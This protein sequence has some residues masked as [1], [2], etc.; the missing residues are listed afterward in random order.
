MKNK[1]LEIVTC[2]LAGGHGPE[3]PLPARCGPGLNTNNLLCILIGHKK[4]QTPRLKLVRRVC[5]G[6][7]I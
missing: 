3:C 4:T 1:R 7:I 2:R 5:D 6:W